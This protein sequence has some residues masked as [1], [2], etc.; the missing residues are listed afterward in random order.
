[1]SDQREASPKKEGVAKLVEFKSPALYAAAERKTAE[2]GKLFDNIFQ[3]GPKYSPYT[4]M[5]P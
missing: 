1:M 4:S 3:I 2:K 5:K